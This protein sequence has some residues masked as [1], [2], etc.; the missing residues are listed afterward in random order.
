MGAHD[1][2][3]GDVAMGDAVGGLLLHL[4]QDVADNLGVVVGPPHG[5][6]DVDGDIAELRPRQRVVEVVLEEV[7]LGQ[8]LEVGVLDEG[9]VGVGEHANVHG[10][11][12]GRR[13]GADERMR[14][15]RWRSRRR[16]E[17]SMPAVE[18]VL[19]WDWRAH[20]WGF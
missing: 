3:A 11:R 20:E 2:E 7:V 1:A 12:T 9:Q 18:L 5:P 17:G 16:R 14:S 8:V 4:G 15:S 6:R 10:G 19:G 13:A